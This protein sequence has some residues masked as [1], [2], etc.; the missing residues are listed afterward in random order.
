MF[1]ESK[2]WGCLV[3]GRAMVGAVQL[4]LGYWRGWGYW[5]GAGT[6][7]KVQ[8]LSETWPDIEP[9]GSGAWEIQFCDKIE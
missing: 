9:S 4:V 2:G 1:L 6:S 3:E 5:R 8:L 7:N